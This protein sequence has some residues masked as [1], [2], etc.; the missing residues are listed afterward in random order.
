MRA[1]KW[2]REN[3]YLFQNAAPLILLVAGMV[4]LITSLI[5]LSVALLIVAAVCWSIVFL[6]LTP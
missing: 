2:A 1:I 3:V 5:L 6:V 4:A